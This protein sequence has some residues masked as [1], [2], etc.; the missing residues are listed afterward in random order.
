[1][2]TFY[3]FNTWQGLFYLCLGLIL[4]YNI[5]R[6]V[7]SL[8]QNFLNKRRLRKKLLASFDAILLLVK[9][10]FFL[11]VVLDFIAINYITHGIFLALVAGVAYLPLSN[12]IHGM[13]LKMNPM[14]S[15]NTLIKI[16]E[17]QGEIR[18]LLPL[19]MML[20]TEKGQSFLGYA[21]ISATGFSVSSKDTGRHRHTVYMH[22]AITKDSL[23][24]MLFDNPIL[25][26]QD[27]PTASVDS[28]SA[29]IKLQYTL[30]E[31]ASKE[32]FMAFLAENDLQTTLTQNHE[33]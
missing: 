11:V 23:L 28:A 25:N 9:P 3:S 33:S 16:G 7:R 6:G 30:E 10:I 32:D 24:D 14:I 26:L 12:Y 5:L 2:E 8:I 29:L 21:A 19:G 1:M 13:L 18:E 27:P 15:K 4:S 17:V 31:G 20:N 22:N